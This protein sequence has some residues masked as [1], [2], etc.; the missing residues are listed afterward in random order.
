MRLHLPGPRASSP[1]SGQVSEGLV[2][3]IEFQSFGLAELVPGTA[4]KLL[5]V[6]NWGEG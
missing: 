1:A 6:A 2:P 3:V 5:T 4:S